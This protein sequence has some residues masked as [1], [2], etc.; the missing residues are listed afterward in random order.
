MGDRQL[1]ALIAPDPDPHRAARRAVGV[2]PAILRLQRTAGNAAIAALLQRTPSGGSPTPASIGEALSKIKLTKTTDTVREL[3]PWEIFRLVPANTPTKKKLYLELKAAWSALDA[4]KRKL[5]AADKAASAGASAGATPAALSR[6]PKGKGKAKHAQTVDPAA[7]RAAAAKAVESAQARVDKAI[8]AI[9]QFIAENDPAVRK[10][11]AD[12]RSLKKSL[13]GKEKGLAALKAKPTPDQEKVRATEA[14]IASLQQELSA[15]S[16]R[17]QDAI[18]DVTKRLAHTSFAPEEVER[19]KYAFEIEGESVTLLDRVNSWATMYEQGLEEAKQAVGRKLDDVLAATALS[20]S[21]KKILA[22]ISDNESGAA[23]WSSV[24]TYDRAVLTWGLVQ[25]TGGSHSD[26]TAA[27]TT[28][29]LTAP[30]AFA[31]R[32]EKY[33]IDVINDELVI[34]GADGSTTKG[35]AAALGIM[36]S[37]TLSAVMA[38]AGLDSKIQEGEVDAAA[39]QQIIEPLSATFTVNGPRPGG[40]GKAKDADKAKDQPT[41]KDKDAGRQGKGDKVKLRYADV[42]TSEYVVGLFADQVVNAGKGKA[43]R[44]VADAVRAYLQRTGENPND[45][46]TWAPRLQATLIDLLS[47]FA[48][49]AVSFGARGCSKAAG[50]YKP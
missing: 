25:W 19:T 22:A 46:A 13:G 34:T 2:A 37:P 7:A 33:G 21:N 9:K 44:H 38:R 23:P 4:A 8:D 24:N 29:K 31:E 35:D 28:I 15:V 20:E 47:P 26:L 5:T 10:A 45:F 43:Q 6:A 41:G 27:L 12:E 11:A 39:Q 1:D 3:E 16:H 30:D 36:G 18:D 32:F 49:R 42:L 48:N 14:A 17:R 40:A 50:S